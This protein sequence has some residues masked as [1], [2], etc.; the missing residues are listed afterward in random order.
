MKKIILGLLMLASILVYSGCTQQ[1]QQETCKSPYI[2]FKLG[3]CCLDSNSNN[4][5]D[6]DEE[7]EPV[8]VE[9]YAEDGT[10][11]AVNVAQPVTRCYEKNPEFNVEKSGVS[12]NL[13]NTWIEATC[14]INNLENERVTFTYT[15]KSFAGAASVV[16]QVGPKTVTVGPNQ[17]YKI[18]EGLTG[19]GA[20]GSATNFLCDIK[21]NPIEI[22][23]IVE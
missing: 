17:Q 7:K 9:E 22:C 10:D 14:I 6:N 13:E 20:P 23:E 4:I 16:G 1:P 8:V 15:I 18:V 11:S 21:A 3:E 5:C 19:G 12:K 2:E